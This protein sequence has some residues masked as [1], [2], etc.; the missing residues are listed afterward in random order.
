MCFFLKDDMR[1][2][3]E[4]DDKINPKDATIINTTSPTKF[5]KPTNVKQ[6]CNGSN[7]PKLTPVFK[8]LFNK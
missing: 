8:G 2:D 5:N 3:V 6:K 4:C 7:E 1:S